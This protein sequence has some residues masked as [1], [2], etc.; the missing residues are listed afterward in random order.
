MSLRHPSVV[1]TAVFLAAVSLT[2]TLHAGEV[3]PS[4]AKPGDLVS[5][6]GVESV[7][8][9]PLVVF[10][11]ESAAA[12]LDDV[13]V[14]PG[15]VEGR[16]GPVAAP[17]FGDVEVWWGRRVSLPKQVSKQG[18][19]TY[20]PRLV[21][22]FVGRTHVSPSGG[23]LV[24]DNGSSDT[25]FAMAVA[26]SEVDLSVP[27]EPPLGIG[28]DGCHLSIRVDI[29]IDGGSATNSGTGPGSE[30]SLVRVGRLE[31][32]PLWVRTLIGG[33][34]EPPLIG[35]HLAKLVNLHFNAV[36]IAAE[37]SGSTL[38]VYSTEGP[39]ERAFVTVRYLPAE[40]D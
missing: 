33:G 3:E 16:L 29:I 28:C 37:G 22:A 23:R 4:S 31:L 5:V 40:S 7:P 15:R 39:F 2:S 8:A 27:P 11:S 6:S 24:V 9:D 10:F 30:S 12:V 18:D 20:V 19:M 21:E 25:V 1:L 34:S 14:S 32:A 36:G 35:E 13:R 26:A 17:L 38:A